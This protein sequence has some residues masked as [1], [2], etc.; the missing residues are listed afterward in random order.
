MERLFTFAL[1]KD[2][3]MVP[4]PIH[5]FFFFERGKE[6]MFLTGSSSNHKP[7]L[8]KRLW[9]GELSLRIRRQAC[10]SPLNPQNP[11]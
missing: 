6:Y 4:E 2:T 7:I 11:T 9:A 1:Y 5:L 3:F 8:D 10:F